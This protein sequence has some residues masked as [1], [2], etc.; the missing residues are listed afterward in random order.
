[1]KTIVFAVLIGLLSCQSFAQVIVSGKIVD[2]KKN[3]SEFATVALLNAKDSTLVKASLTSIEGVYSFEKISNGVYRIA[4]SMVGYKRTFSEK[5]EV[6]NTNT[7]VPDL[8]LMSESKQ[9][10]EV[11][12]TARKPFLEQ[13]AD[14]LVVNIAGT[15]SSMGLS[16]LEV[17][18]RVPGL[19]VMNDAVSMIGKSS[20]TIMIDGRASRYTDVSIVLRSLQ[21]SN[22]ERIEVISNPSAKYDASG[23]GIINIIMK[24]DANLGTNGTVSI[25]G[26]VFPYNLQRNGAS[27]SELFHQLNPS[28]SLNHCKGQWNIFGNYS[29]QNRKQFETNEITRNIKD[30]IYKQ[31]N[32]NPSINNTHN[33]MT[34]VDFY[35][36]KRNTIGGLISWSNRSETG[37]FDN[38]T[39]QIARPNTKVVSSFTSQNTQLTKRANVNYNLNWKHTFDSTGHELNIDID[40]GKYDINSNNYFLF[41]YKDATNSVKS[42]NQ[43]VI[44]PVRFSTLKIDYTRPLGKDQK[45]ELGA[46]LSDASIDYDVNFKKNEVIDPLRTNKFLYSEQINSAYITYYNRWKTWELQAGLRAEQTVAQGKSENS[47]VLDRNYWQPFPSIFLTKRMGEHFALTGSVGR[48]INRPSYQQQNPFKFFIDPLTY[49]QGNPTLLPE[50]ITSSKIGL[51]YDGMPFISVSTNTTNDIIIDA[52]RQEGNITFTQAQNIASLKNIT[53]EINFPLNFGRRITGFGGVQFIR[54][55]YEAEYLGENFNLSKWTLG[56]AVHVFFKVSETVSADL[57]GHYMSP[58][59]QGFF[60]GQTT[61]HL[62]F[63]LAKKLWNKKARIAM[64]VNDVFYT[65]NTTGVIKYKDIDLYLA[66]LTDSRDIRISFNYLFGNQILKK[67]R[68]RKTG[69]ETESGRVK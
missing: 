61:G 33:L 68:E 10:Q 36:N 50:M 34:G 52:P 44:N 3:A 51:S 30:D 17:M 53:T 66:R 40:H 26:G 23:G 55:Q 63:V 59:I 64:V 56:G 14:K 25:T 4:V 22:I 41:N 37:D 13:R 54:N 42:S 12:V 6:D 28:F 62:S 24:R 58:F 49:Q 43:N 65:T 9:L 48:R 69:S 29:F 32:V 1:M 11:V 35:L 8:Q 67:S 19:V 27:G 5:F 46:K 39:E 45:I 7:I 2:E 60:E 20:V 47:V 31:K 21:S 18:Q 16:A 15:L 38:F 57:H